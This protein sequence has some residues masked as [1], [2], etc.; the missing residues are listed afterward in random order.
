[1]IHREINLALIMLISSLNGETALDISTKA[2][3][4]F[5]LGSL[6]FIDQR[7]KAG[8]KQRLKLRAILNQTNP[9]KV[10]YMN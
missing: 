8:P 7:N 3:F 5:Y 6:A 9:S 4:S 2:L 10:C 1:M